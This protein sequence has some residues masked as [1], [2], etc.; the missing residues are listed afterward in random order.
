MRTI[1]VIAQISIETNWRTMPEKNSAAAKNSVPVRLI[2]SAEISGIFIFE[3]PYVS[4]VANA[5]VQ[6]AVTSSKDDNK[7]IPPHIYYM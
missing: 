4:E 5:S 7:K 1:L 2:I 3:M 6:S